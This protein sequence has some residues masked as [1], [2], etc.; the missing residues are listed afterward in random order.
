MSQ[1][2]RQHTFS[3]IS[4]KQWLLQEGQYFIKQS[5]MTQIPLNIQSPGSR[6]CAGLVQLNYTWQQL[7]VTMYNGTYLFHSDVVIT[8]FNI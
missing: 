7:T 1:E 8:Y 4:Q 5:Y 3:F 2:V 6:R